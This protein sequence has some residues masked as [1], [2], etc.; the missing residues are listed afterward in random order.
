MHPA[1]IYFL[2]ALV[3]FVLWFIGVA[4]WAGVRQSSGRTR[5]GS[6][7][8]DGIGPLGEGWLL[9]GRLA[10]GIPTALGWPALFVVLFFLLVKRLTAS[11][12]RARA[13]KVEVRRRELRTKAQ[14]W[15]VLAKVVGQTI[16]T[17]AACRATAQSLRDQADALV[18]PPLAGKR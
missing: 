3:V 11:G 4:V 8:N 18:V 1:A 6:F 14:E 10:L 7:W 15:D 5:S 12:Y 17:V 9:V 13:L 16:D 2:I